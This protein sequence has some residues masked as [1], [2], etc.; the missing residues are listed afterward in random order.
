MT[1]DD[2]PNPELGAEAQRRRELLA[3]LGRF[4]VYAPPAMLTLMLSRRASAESLGLPPDPP[5]P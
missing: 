3:Q 2:V 1:H 4:A 5:E